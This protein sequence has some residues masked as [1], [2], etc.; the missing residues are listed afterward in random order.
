MN[1]NPANMNLYRSNM[2]SPS[3]DRLMNICMT[4]VRTIRK[5]IKAIVIPEACMKASLNT[6]WLK[7]V[8]T[9][10]EVNHRMSKGRKGPLLRFNPS[11]ARRGS[12]KMNISLSMIHLTV[13]DSRL[14][15][16]RKP[17]MGSSVFSRP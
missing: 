14:S 15:K 7:D 4:P 2:G 11:N 12:R 1:G 5:A 10:R 13:P 16:A 17:L 9:K 3:Y 6:K 8:M